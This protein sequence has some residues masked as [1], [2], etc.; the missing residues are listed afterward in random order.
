[1]FSSDSL[2]YNLLNRLF[3]VG[4][5][6]GAYSIENNTFNK[7]VYIYDDTTYPPINEEE[8]K[9]HMS[10]IKA[11]KEIEVLS[12]RK[13]VLEKNINKYKA[14]I[15]RL[16]IGQQKDKALSLAQELTTKNNRLK[17]LNTNITQIQMYMEKL[18]STQ[19]TSNTIATLNDMNSTMKNLSSG[20][21]IDYVENILDTKSELQ[22]D[23]ESINNLLYADNKLI[24]SPNQDA[25]DII[26]IIEEEINNASIEEN[27][28]SL[29]DNENT[30]KISDN[31]KITDINDD[32]LLQNLQ[33]EINNLKTND[34]IT[35][36]EA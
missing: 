20:L 4:T 9:I 3:G 18:E 11:K 16:M 28:K 33:E 8:N 23:Q 6:T 30:D 10:V 14:E 35:P 1:M 19:D 26:N 34:I 15:K 13:D 21:N 31:N 24:S 5:V 25:E 27:I 2:L 29:Y 12:K 7:S 32:I 36:I 22:D 17:I